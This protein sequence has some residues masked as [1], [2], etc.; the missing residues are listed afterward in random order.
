MDNLK[1]VLDYIRNFFSGPLDVP[2]KRRA[3][4]NSDYFINP[5][6][7]KLSPTMSHRIPN[8]EDNWLLGRRPSINRP[9]NP[10]LKET[11]VVEEN[12][13]Q[14]NRPSSYKFNSSN[15]PSSTP[16]DIRFRQKPHTNGIED[17]VKFVREEKSV[18]EKSQQAKK[19]GLN[20]LST[21]SNNL[22]DI[23]SAKSTPSL[24]QNGAL[25]KITKSMSTINRN[26]H[27]NS[28]MDFSIRLDDKIQYKKLLENAGNISANSSIYYTPIGKLFK[29]DSPPQSRSARMLAMATDNADKRRPSVGSTGRDSFGSRRLSTKDQI[30]K[31]LDDLD[32]EP[33]VVPDDESDDDVV[34]CPPSPE[35]DI[36]V[37]PVNTLKKVIDCNQRS[38]HDWLSDLIE[39]HR[40]N[41]EVRQREVEEFRQNAE[42]YG[43]INRDIQRLHITSKINHS[44]S[45]KESVLPVDEPCEEVALPELT[46]QHLKMVRRAF[47]GDPNEVLTRKFNLNITRRDLMTLAGLNWLNDEVI[48]FYMNLL[49][50]RG[51]ESQWPKTYAMNTFFYSKIIKDGPESVRRWTR[52]VDLFSYDI[53]CVP[54]H[55]GMHWCMAIIDLRD[56]SVRYFDSMG[57]TNNRCLDALRNYLEFEHSDKKK[58]P[59]DTSD[60]KLENVK[61][62][63]QQMNGSDCGMFSCTFAEFLTRNSKI[64]FS[65]EDMP[66]LRKKMVVEIMTGELLIK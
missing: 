23:K 36:K 61:D 6:C 29:P 10:P 46:D 54:I 18:F 3:V 11:I 4:D 42:S 30:I 50:E 44:L 53:I 26:T 65:Q 32:T 17:D 35:P 13:I 19:S 49:M 37:E 8:T 45:L 25:P 39:N 31:I 14:I 43:S 7:R 56:R 63:P 40:K 24:H 2:R 41:I 33:V 55:L 21:L 27:K 62:I 12:D 16:V 1:G 47:S 22:F 60:F 5:K 9:K 38:K 34:V 28:S 66:Y 48:N 51:K 57:S 58:S 64:T 52:R 15:I 59:L 20:Y